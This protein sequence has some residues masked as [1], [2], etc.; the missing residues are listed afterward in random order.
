MRKSAPCLVRLAALRFN[1][2]SCKC[3]NKR[4][5]RPEGVG[6]D[7]G[8]RVR[9]HVL[10]PPK[11]VRQMLDHEYHERFDTHGMVLDRRADIEHHNTMIYTMK[12]SA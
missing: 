3:D 4:L 5:C 2:K 6:S 9:A 8:A 1:H 12:K 7:L 10:Q 11:P